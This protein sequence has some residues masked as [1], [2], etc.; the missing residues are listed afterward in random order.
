LV[1]NRVKIQASIVA[2]VSFILAQL[3]M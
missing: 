2:N 1:K 3:N